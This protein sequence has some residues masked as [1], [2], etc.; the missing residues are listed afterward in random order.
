MKKTTWV[1]IGLSLTVL[2]LA[3]ALGVV[4]LQKKAETIFVRVPDD[5]LSSYP[6]T[7]S[8]IFSFAHSKPWE[9]FSLAPLPIN[10][11]ERKGLAVSHYGKVYT[12]MVIPGN[13]VRV[14]TPYK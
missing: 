13:K 10:I 12:Y 1:I 9:K 14:I 5:D 7:S 4:L 2:I 11:F 3:T 6:Y 8:Y